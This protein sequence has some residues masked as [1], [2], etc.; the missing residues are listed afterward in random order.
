MKLKMIFDFA[1]QVFNL[2]RQRQVDLRCR[3]LLFAV[4]LLA[5]CGEYDLYAK[6]LPKTDGPVK[7]EILQTNGGYQLYVDHKPFYIKG[8]GL[9]SGD[10]KKLAACGGNSFRT[11]QTDS[12][13][14]S[15]GQILDQALTNGLYVS[16]GLEIGRE[17]Q[18]FDYN[19]PADVARQ[20]EKSK[21][22][23][24]NTRIIQP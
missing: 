20:L 5:C 14:S 13:R 4:G 1:M 7:V 10:Q 17:R 22:R 12:R 24:K 18:G 11:W 19:N 6:P 2:H 9:G 16:L 21:P 8:A 3:G 15:G 23:F